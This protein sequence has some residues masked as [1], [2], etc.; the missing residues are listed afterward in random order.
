MVE[1]G[2]RYYYTPVSGSRELLTRSDE[3]DSYVQLIEKE[4]FESGSALAPIF[5]Y[6]GEVLG[7]VRIK[8]ESVF[9]PKSI[10]DFL[11]AQLTPIEQALFFQFFRLSY[12]E[13][14]NFC[15][16]GKRE[17]CGRTGISERRLNLGLDGL[18][19]KGFIKPLH[20]N[21][22][23]TLFLVVFPEPLRK[24]AQFELE[25]GKKRELKVSVEKG[26]EGR[27]GRVFRA[28]REKPIESPLNIEQ[29]GDFSKGGTQ[30]ISVKEI[31]EKFFELKRKKPAPE[32][33]DQAISVVTSLLEDGFS[34]EEVLFAVEWFCNKFLKEK[35]LSSLPYYINQA[36]GEMG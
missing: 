28:P 19:R 36:L 32:E 17:L 34:R 26:G 21:T 25:F 29:F 4:V 18:V 8:G 11:T 7:G 15:R 30:K 9:V 16:V 24:E 12:G 3:D 31:A 27:Q 1:K 5:E 23:G 33:L 22:K 35:D 10:F 20:R 14:R 13:G 2:K 6:Q